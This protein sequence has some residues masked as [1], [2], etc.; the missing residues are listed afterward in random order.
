[1]IKKSSYLF[2]LYFEN[3]YYKY[4]PCQ[5]FKPWLW[6]EARLFEL[7]I[8]YKIA[9]HYSIKKWPSSKERVGSREDVMSSNQDI[10]TNVGTLVCR[11][12][13]RGSCFTLVVCF[14]LCLPWK[15]LCHLVVVLSWLDDVAR[16]PLIQII[17][18]LP[19]G[20]LSNGGRVFYKFTRAIS[21]QQWCILIQI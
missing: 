2:F 14:C 4:L 21:S 19:F 20:D 1:M 7:R 5:I 12:V 13:V 3:V 17:A 6:G 18:G 10:K 8:L 11:R 9:C 15:R 16:R